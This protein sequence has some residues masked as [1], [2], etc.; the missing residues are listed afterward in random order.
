MK[1]IK[2][3]VEGMF[4]FLYTCKFSKHVDISGYLSQTTPMEK[5]HVSLKTSEIAAKHFQVLV[6]QCNATM[7]DF[8]SLLT[9]TYHSD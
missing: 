1:A 5:C 8:L 2:Y 7:K 4:G 3:K 9:L 6:M